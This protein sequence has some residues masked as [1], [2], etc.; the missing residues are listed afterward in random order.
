[1]GTF[2][3]LLTFSIFSDF[4]FS[5][6]T[7]GKETQISLSPFKIGE[8]IFKVLSIYSVGL[9]GLLSTTDHATV[10]WLCP[11][12]ELANQLG[13]MVVSLIHAVMTLDV[14]VDDIR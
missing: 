2:A 10:Q 14:T 3:I 8:D 13:L 6:K 11:P 7:R 1:M 5:P 12:L 9:F 4:S